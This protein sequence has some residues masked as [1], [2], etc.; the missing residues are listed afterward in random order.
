[1]SK[2]AILFN[3]ELVSDNRAS[4]LMS[5]GDPGLFE[6]MR[7]YKRKMLYLRQHL[8]RMKDGAAILG[9]RINSLAQL[10]LLVKKAVCISGLRD[11]YVKLIA[12]KAGAGIDTLV[13]VRKYHPFPAQRYQ[14]GFSIETCACRSQNPLAQ[15]KTTNRI[16]YELLFNSATK[17]GFDEALILNHLGYITET[18][19]ANIFFV[20]GGVLFTPAL[21]CGCLPGITRRVVFD[22]APRFKIKIYEGN[23]LPTDLYSA[24]EAFLTNS[25]MGIMPIDSLNRS[26]IGNKVSRITKF[27]GKEYQRLFKNAI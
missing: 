17:K 1:M 18:T 8:E 27:L 23:Y 15:L 4:D 3:G 7:A 22:L 2:E 24:D 25:L 16:F 12:R 5:G 10:E 19:R 9:L 14:K 6:T 13:I 20:K 26:P 21:N 11:A